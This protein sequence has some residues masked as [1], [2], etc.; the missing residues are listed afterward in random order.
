MEL[1]IT[2]FSIVLFYFRDYLLEKNAGTEA[3]NPVD[4]QAERP[5]AAAGGHQVPGRPAHRRSEGGV[6][7]LDRKVRMTF[8]SMR[9]VL[10][11]WNRNWNRSRTGTVI[12]WYHKS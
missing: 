3:G 6:G 5:A 9:A 4:V 12:K 1:D 11:S 2:I 7:R 10:L 8:F